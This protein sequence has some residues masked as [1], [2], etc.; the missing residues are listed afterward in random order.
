MNRSQTLSIRRGG[1]DTTSVTTT[2]FGLVAGFAA[3]AVF[4]LRLM[5]RL[6]GCRDG[7]PALFARRHRGTLPPLDGLLPRVD[8]AEEEAPAETS[9]ASMTAQPE[10]M[11][12]TA[13]ATATAPPVVAASGHVDKD[14]VEED[15]YLVPITPVQAVDVV[16]TVQ[17]ERVRYT[18]TQ[19]TDVPPPR[20]R[21]AA[22]DQDR[23]ASTSEH[24]LTAAL[25][26]SDEARA[27]LRMDLVRGDEQSRLR[28]RALLRLSDGASIEAVADRLEVRPSTVRSW[29]REFV[30]QCGE[31]VA[32]GAGAG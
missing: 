21:V 24:Q 27:S 32:S 5:G 16:A 26:L 6:C 25:D 10:P 14:D 28:A 3:A 20:I 31:P 22:H 8:L 12:V 23:I 13:P 11:E 19:D 30:A 17:P 9:D 4:A 18:R 29:Q 7:S 2:T 15:P 1:V